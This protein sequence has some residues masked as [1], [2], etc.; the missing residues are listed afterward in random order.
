MDDPH[1]DHSDL[2]TGSMIIAEIG[3]EAFE[4][5]VVTGPAGGQVWREELQFD[6]GALTPG[7]DFRKWYLR[8]LRRLGAI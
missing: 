5:L 3:C 2:L 8:W 4:R 1:M 6:G 7:P